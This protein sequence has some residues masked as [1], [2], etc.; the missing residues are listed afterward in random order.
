M[1]DLSGFWKIQFDEQDQGGF[2]AGFDGG[3]R[4][5][6]G[7]GQTDTLRKVSYYILIG[8]IVSVHSKLLES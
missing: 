5:E 6:R 4:S 2:E 3:E 7:G 1:I 8:T